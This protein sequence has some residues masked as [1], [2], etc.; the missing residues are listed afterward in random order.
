MV[1][2]RDPHGAKSRGHSG[3]TH[4]LRMAHGRVLHPLRVGDIVD[5]A[6]GVDVS[7]YTV[8]TRNDW[9]IVWTTKDM[10]YGSDNGPNTAFGPASTSATR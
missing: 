9:D 7:T 4:R 1:G 3:A 2:A 6:P 5:V 10:L 8:G